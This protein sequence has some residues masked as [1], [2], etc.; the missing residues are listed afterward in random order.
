MLHTHICTYNDIQEQPYI[1]PI[2]AITVSRGRRKFRLNCLFDTW[3]QRIYFCGQVI[4]R[5]GCDRSFLTAVKTFLRSKKDIKPGRIG[6]W[7]RTGCSL[8]L[9][10]LID[11][12]FDIN[13][14]FDD[15][16]SVKNDLINLNYKLTFLHEQN[17]VRVHGLL[18]WL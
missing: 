2:V 12:E 3:N 15:F 9:P 5:V 17:E 1:L 11:D 7:G 10:I 16:K 13:F 6:Y 14:R 18:E 8:A 4:K